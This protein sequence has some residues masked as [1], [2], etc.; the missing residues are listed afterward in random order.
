MWQHVCNTKYIFYLPWQIYI[1]FLSKSIVIFEFCIQII[2]L[3]GKKMFFA[4]RVPIIY[5]KLKVCM[6]WFADWGTLDIYTNICSKCATYSLEYSSSFPSLFATNI[7]YPFYNSFKPPFATYLSRHI[8]S[9]VFD[10]SLHIAVLF[11]NRQF[12]VFSVV[13]RM[14]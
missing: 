10:Q 2:R 14:N 1:N 13:S 12:C 7:S 11:Q 9:N 3:L 6:C 5:K 4:Y 8:L